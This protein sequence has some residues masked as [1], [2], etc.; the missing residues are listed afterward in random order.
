MMKFCFGMS[1]GAGI[2]IAQCFGAGSFRQ[3][4]ETIGSLICVVSVMAAIIMI[5]GIVFARTL[6]SLLSTP[7]EIINDSVTYFRIII[8][9]MPF[10][11]AYNTASAM[12]RSMGDS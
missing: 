8:A 10:T 7:I 4:K 5:I 1:N 9:G 6:L 11:M 12:L 3:L 2:I